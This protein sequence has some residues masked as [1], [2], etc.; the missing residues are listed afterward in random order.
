MQIIQG[1]ILTYLDLITDKSIEQQNQYQTLS[2]ELDALVRF[3]IIL[4]EKEN[5]TKI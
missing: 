1:R 5:L 2:S 4:T 3:W